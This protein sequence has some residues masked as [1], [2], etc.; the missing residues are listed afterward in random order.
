MNPGYIIL[1]RRFFSNSLWTEDRSLSKAEAFLDLLQ[2][3]AFAPTK[4]IIRGSLIEL[5]EGELV[6]SVRYLS[7]RWMW[8][9]DRVSRFIELL[10]KE[11]MVRRQTRH[12]ETVVI[13]CNYKKYNRRPDAHKD[14][15]K[16][17]HKDTGKD[18][19]KDKVEEGKEG[20]EEEVPPNPQGGMGADA[21]NHVLPAGWERMT[22]TQR[23]QTRVNTNSKLMNRIGRMLGRK[24]GTLWTVAEAVALKTVNPQ[25]DEIALM[26]GYY[27]AEID[28]DEDFR[29]RDLIT[30]LNNWNGELDRA[31]I[32]QSTP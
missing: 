31:R 10:E 27:L 2:L 19:H 29:R 1:Q 30:L 9:K 6:A 22:A 23:K 11:S 26:E 20:K 7:D 21:K 12:G 32:H 13:L 17:A 15:G 28:R 16:D 4:R 24:D 14:T 25:A 18:A 5:D 8:S 3:A